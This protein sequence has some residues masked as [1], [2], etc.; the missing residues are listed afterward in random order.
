MG[1][2]AGEDEGTDGEAGDDDI[3]AIECDFGDS[4]FT[5]AILQIGENGGDY[6]EHE[7]LEHECKIGADFS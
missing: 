2:V 5:E 7:D 4:F 1:G 6:G 3:T